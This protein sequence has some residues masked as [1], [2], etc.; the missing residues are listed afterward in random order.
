[1]ISRIRTIKAITQL[2]EST[3]TVRFNAALPISVD[4]L[5]KI[6][7]NRYRLKVG[8][9]EM[10]TRSQKPLQEKKRYWGNFSE[11]KEGILT[12]SN[13]REKPSLLQYHDKYLHVDSLDF[14]E[15]FT[16][17]SSPY[18]AFKEWLLNELSLCTV[19]KDFELLSSMLLALHEGIVHLPLFVYNRPL[20]IQWKESNNKTLNES[21]IDFY[22]AFDNMGPVRGNI[23]LL[24]KTLKM[25]LLFEKTAALFLAH[26]ENA[27]LAFQLDVKES[28]SPLWKGDDALLDIKG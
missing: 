14:L 12:I 9:K 10:T 1:M 6:G 3:Q 7:Y 4:V 15:L 23:D 16:L 25:S 22:L 18:T 8:H 11:S 27:P 28:L 24:A 20:L 21:W 26:Q 17:S 2:M 19:P 5:A 13:L